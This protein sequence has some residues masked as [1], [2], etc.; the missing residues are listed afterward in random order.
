MYSWP[1][2]TQAYTSYLIRCGETTQRGIR[3]NIV[4][5][6]RTSAI[7]QSSASCSR[8]RSRNS[9]ETGTSEIMSAIG[10]PSYA[11]T[12]VM[13]DLHAR[14]GLSLAGHASP[15]RR[16]EPRTAISEKQAKDRSRPRTFRT[17]SLL[18]SSEGEWMTSLSVKKT[19]LQCTGHQ[20]HDSQQLRT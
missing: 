1:S 10:A 18:S 5:I 2:S 17:S 7:P 12:R 16:E 20:G 4:V 9:S 11:T 13:H 15:E 3:T 8:M 14:S 19:H 6:T